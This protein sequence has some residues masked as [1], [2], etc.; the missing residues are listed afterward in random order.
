[1]GRLIAILSCLTFICAQAAA[2]AYSGQD[3]SDRTIWQATVKSDSATLYSSV[4]AGSK[5][6]KL[7][8]RGEVVEINLEIAQSEATWYN[9]T[10]S[11]EAG[12]S[13]YMNAKDLAV[14]PLKVA[15]WEFKPPPEPEVKPDD[16]APQTKR[17]QR[18]FVSITK[19]K[20]E[21]E[22]K[23]FF[24]SKFGHSLPVSAFGQTALHSRLG[25]DH[26]HS[27]DVALHPDSAEGRALVEHLRSRGIPFIAFRRAV[28]GVATGPHVHV[29][30]PSRRR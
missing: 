23:G 25:F 14:E 4:S 22:I 15:S 26:S 10:T 17:A 21:K 1:M 5:V 30:L 18:L 6:V 28:P 3:D 16:A 20:L 2:G 9:V 7:L 29:G 12:A 27:M 8:S 19:S 11:E 13:G 24:A